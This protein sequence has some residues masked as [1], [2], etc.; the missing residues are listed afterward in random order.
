MSHENDFVPTV[1]VGVQY[2]YFPIKNLSELGGPYPSTFVK[3]T[4][5]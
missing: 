3:G 4:V 5:P 1:Y 2:Y